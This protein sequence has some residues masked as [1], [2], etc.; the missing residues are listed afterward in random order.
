MLPTLTG[1]AV[2][3][4]QDASARPVLSR[5]QLTDKIIADATAAGFA[6]T[7]DDADMMVAL[8]IRTRDEAGTP[9]QNGR[10]PESVLTDHELDRLHDIMNSLTPDDTTAVP[11]SGSLHEELDRYTF[12]T[13][14]VTGHAR[15][16]V[17]HTLDSFDHCATV[18]TAHFAGTAAG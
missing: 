1:A 2:T 12:G 11:G 16:G 17:V 10:R 5:K 15:G 6:P 8:W 3:T 14:P 7:A 9:R 13:D 18:T 4:E